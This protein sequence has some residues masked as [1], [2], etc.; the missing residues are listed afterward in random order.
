MKRNLFTK[1]IVVSVA[2]SA[3]L[4]G[5]GSTSTGVDTGSGNNGDSNV[6]KSIS[7][8][9]IDGYLQNAVVCLDLNQDGYCQSH[10]EPMTTT[11]SDG[12][13][14]LDI[15]QAQRDNANFDEAMLLI[16][17]GVDVD[18]KR[19]FTGKLMAPNDGSSLLN[20]SPITTI[21]AKN[22]QKALKAERGL[23]RE[24]IKDKIKEARKK[25]AVA[26][27]IGEDE[28]GLDPV[29]RKVAGDDKLI[30]KALQI[31]KSF[32]AQLSAAQTAN[33][34]LKEKIDDLYEAL[35]DGL[36]DMQDGEVGLDKLYERAVQKQLFKETLK[37]QS[38]EQMIAIADKIGK[39]LDDA[40]DDHE[41]DGD[42]EKIAAISRDD[43]DKIR[44]GAKS[45]DLST[46]IEGIVYVPTNDW[47]KKYIEHDLLEIGIKPTD[48]L[49]DKLKSIYG[50]DI[51][52]GVLL[53][54]SDKLKE[55]NDEQLKEVY[56]KILI[57]KEKQKREKEAEDAR[58]DKEVKV[59]LKAI[60]SEKT[61]YVIDE[62][63]VF[64]LTFNTEV[65]SVIDDENEE[66]KL[67]IDGNSIYAIDDKKGKD[68]LTY[69]TQTDEY[70]EFYGDDSELIRFY[71][72]KDKA[73]AYANTIQKKF[74]KREDGYQS[75]ESDEVSTSPS[76]DYEKSFDSIYG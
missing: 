23:T 53:E 57:L 49:V 13:F 50:D 66:T 29:E 39:N 43:I 17:G 27:E 41:I 68:V 54:K 70:Y 15:T 48:A 42:L 38:P 31:Q 74:Q 9:A 67:K 37:G 11:L 21:V 47:L 20:V 4:A 22:V 72:E 8:K 44:E 56:Q 12:S 19:D 25:V 24:Q 2:L 51:R 59:N 76:D 5:C 36:D 45:G 61:F 16:F 33:K 60:F 63:G 1:S 52:A 10:S 73:E 65:N 30:R 69:K 64:A 28:V 55:S 40:F 3:L 7:G 62:D 58:Y 18:T 35:A 32:E 34:D 14:Q 71:K 26:L 6:Q 46:V 75:G